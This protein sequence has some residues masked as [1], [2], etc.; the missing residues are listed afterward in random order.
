MNSFD[1]EKSKKFTLHKVYYE[2]RIERLK[3]NFLL[4][5]NLKVDSSRRQEEMFL[6]V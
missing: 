6:H 2:L 4:F 5:I 1:K 3:A